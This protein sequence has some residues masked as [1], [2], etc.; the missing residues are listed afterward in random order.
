MGSARAPLRSEAAHFGPKQVVSDVLTRRAGRVRSP[1]GEVVDALGREV[2][3]VD[4][5][6]RL[7]A[8]AG[9]EPVVERVTVVVPWPGVEAFL[10]YRLSTASTA[11]PRR[12]RRGAP[13]GGGGRAATRSVACVAVRSGHCRHQPV[14]PGTGAVPPPASLVP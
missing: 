13:T 14:R 3:S 2:G 6:A 5:V 10:G 9:L 8:G 1:V 12:R 11:R 4:A 7:L